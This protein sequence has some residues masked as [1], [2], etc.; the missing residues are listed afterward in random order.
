MKVPKIIEDNKHLFGTYST[1]ALMNTR[2]V[3]NYIQKVV[4]IEGEM[5]KDDY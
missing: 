4:N 2:T 5:P 1:M 3:F